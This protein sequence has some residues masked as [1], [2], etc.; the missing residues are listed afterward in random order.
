MELDIRRHSQTLRDLAVE[1]IN[2]VIDKYGDRRSL[3]IDVLKTYRNTLQ[4]NSYLKY[5]ENFNPS[6][7]LTWHVEME[8]TLKKSNTFVELWPTLAKEIQ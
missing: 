5:Q 6:K 3:A 4:D 8:N 1:E 7:T 2:R